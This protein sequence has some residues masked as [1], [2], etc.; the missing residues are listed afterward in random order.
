[1]QT[2]EETE[3]AARQVRLAAMEWTRDDL[4]TY[5]FLTFLWDCS[6]LPATWDVNSM[7]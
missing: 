6:G 5:K 2:N 3:K 4:G 1:M 7:E